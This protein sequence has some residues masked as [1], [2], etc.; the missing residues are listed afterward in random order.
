[1]GSAEA[2]VMVEQPTKARRLPKMNERAIAKAEQN[3][4]DA[5]GGPR[6]LAENLLNLGQ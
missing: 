4:A 1:M 5:H 2:K 3:N 6:D